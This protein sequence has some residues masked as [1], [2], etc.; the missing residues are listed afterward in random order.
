MTSTPVQRGRPGFTLIELLVVI[1]IIAVLIALL[2]PAVQSAREAARRAQCVNNLKQL[3]LAVHNYIARTEALPA[4]TLDNSQTWGW[5]TPWTALILP[6]IEQ[7]PLY[8]ALNFSLPMLELGFISPFYGANTTV[9]LTSIGVLFCPSEPLQKS[10]SFNAV[11]YAMM[12]YA[13]NFGGP[14]MIRSCSG[15]IVPV[16]GNL[17]FGLMGLLGSPVPASAG[18]V[19][20]ASITDGTSNTALFSEHLLAYGNGVFAVTD[21]SVTPGGPNARRGI[22]QTTFNVVLDQGSA[23][24]AL[25]FV[26]ACQSLPGGTQAV[27]DDAF[28]AQWLLSMDYAVANNGYTHVMPPN[29]LSC[30][31]TPVFGVSDPSWGGVASATTPSSYHP[32]GVNI[33]FSDGSVRFVKNSIGLPTWWALGSRNGSEIVSADQY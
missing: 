25:A 3:G 32:G 5:F 30:I 33:C 15:T 11:E 8:N 31:G 4:H 6:D 13:G 23:A 24:N 12:N 21:P 26:A 20:I 14:A 10:P 16:Q 18:P 7:Q 27:T 28:G 17:I 19:R 22:F 1:A 9:G 2:L 29:G